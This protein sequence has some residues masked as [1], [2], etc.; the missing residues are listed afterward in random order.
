MSVAG[1]VTHYFLEKDKANLLNEE[2]VLSFNFL[3]NHFFTSIEFIQMIVDFEQQFGISFNDQQLKSNDFA[4][5]GKL[6]NLIELQVSN[7][8]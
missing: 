6:I 5:V 3:E 7:T 4:I 2:M 1:Y 8:Q